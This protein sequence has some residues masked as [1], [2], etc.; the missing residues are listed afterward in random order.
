MIKVEKIGKE[1]PLRCDKE[2]A[3]ALSYS[4]AA[5]AICI[6]EIADMDGDLS[7]EEF[8]GVVKSLCKHSYDEVKE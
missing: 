4:F 1:I 8:K 2:G 6:S 3:K 7:N 5:M